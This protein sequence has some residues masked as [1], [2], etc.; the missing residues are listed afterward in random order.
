MFKVDEFDLHHKTGRKNGEVQSTQWRN[1]SNLSHET[2]Q[3]T[4]V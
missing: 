3:A 4:E 1:V 2:G